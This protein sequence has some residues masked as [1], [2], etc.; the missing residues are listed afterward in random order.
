LT[1][2]DTAKEARAIDIPQ[3]EA[4][5]NATVLAAENVKD[6]NIETR[7]TVLE[8]EKTKAEN[9]FNDEKKFL[10]EHW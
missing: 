9:E 8:E 1:S 3:A 6:G 7:K 5:R 4:L 2:F 10:V